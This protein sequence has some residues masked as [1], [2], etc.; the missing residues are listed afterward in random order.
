MRLQYDVEK[1]NQIKY[2]LFGNMQ[3]VYLFKGLLLLFSLV[4]VLN[5]MA[6]DRSITHAG[7]KR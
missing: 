6:Y 7:S 4:L 5:F 3:K 2:D 1:I